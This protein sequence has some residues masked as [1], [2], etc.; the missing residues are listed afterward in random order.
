MRV[1]VLRHHFFAGAGLARDQHRDV[2]HRI[3]IGEIQNFMKLRRVADHRRRFNCV[4][5]AG[6]RR[7]MI[8]VPEQS[9]KAL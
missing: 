4:R 5:M 7:C 1:N 9:V 6:I 2:V 3:A 8:D